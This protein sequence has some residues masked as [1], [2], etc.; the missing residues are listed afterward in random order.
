MRRNY[1]CKH[2]EHWGHSHL[3]WTYEKSLLRVLIWIWRGCIIWGIDIVV[4]QLTW[5]LTEHRQVTYVNI[6]NLLLYKLVSTKAS[7]KDNTYWEEAP[8]PRKKGLVV[9]SD[10]QANR[11]EMRS[12]DSWTTPR[13]LK[14]W[15]YQM[16][17]SLVHTYSTWIVLWSYESRWAND[18][19]RNTQD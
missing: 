3:I 5:V 7:T 17:S 18:D 12:V 11:A 14:T 10:K 1:L 15:L 4:S 6:Y 9:Q 2:H 16:S 13:A 19:D 8:T